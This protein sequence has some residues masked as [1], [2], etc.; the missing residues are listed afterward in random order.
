MRLH[1]TCA[2]Q[3]SDHI[4]LWR[5][6]NSIDGKDVSA[7]SRVRISQRQRD[8][9]L[10]HELGARHDLVDPHHLVVLV[11]E[12]VAVPDVQAVEIFE[13]GDHPHRLTAIDLDGVF[14]AKL[15]GFQGNLPELARNTVQ[16]LEL[17]QVQVNG[18]AVGRR[19]G[20]LPDLRGPLDRK[21]GRGVGPFRAVQQQFRP[22]EFIHVFDQDSCR[23][24][25][26]SLSGMRGTETNVSGRELVS[27]P[28]EATTRNFITCPVVLGSA[29][30]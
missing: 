14:P 25:I 28:V 11:L 6:Q 7:G 26:A 18:V 3:Q 19:I 17:D 5:G 15:M 23:V 20:D 12:D 2:S 4:H 9:L 13:L 8:S 16:H 24:T 29:G 1:I 30:V 22:A 21:L 27:G 10:H